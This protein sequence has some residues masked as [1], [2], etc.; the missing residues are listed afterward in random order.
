MIPV[1]PLD[2]QIHISKAGSPLIF[3]YT[4]ME[5]GYFKIK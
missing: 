2:I 4:Y 5:M 3:M 1:F